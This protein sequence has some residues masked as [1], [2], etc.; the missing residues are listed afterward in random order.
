[1]V[2]INPAQNRHLHSVHGAA[3]RVR[4][5]GPF[6]AEAAGESVSI[7]SRKAK[8]VIAYLA[9][10]HGTE[11]ARGVLAGLLWGER[12][13]DQARAS[14]RQT[15]SEIRAAFS[16]AAT[17]PVAAK[18]EAVAW[19]TGAAWVDAHEIAAAVSSEDALTLNEAALLLRG[20]F[21]EGL[22]IGEPGFDQWLTVER[23]RVR[24]MACDI[25]A[26]LMESA[27]RDGTQENALLYG[28]RLL[29][30]D[31]LQE[32]VHR[33]L[34]RIYAAQNRPDAAL[35]QFER[36]KA[37]LAGQ[38]N[39]A[40]A[41]ETTNLER[42][43]KSARR[44]PLAVSVPKS[45][46]PESDAPLIL[47]DKPS[48]VVLP[49]INLSNDPAQDFIADGMTED[50]IS[51]LSRIGKLF[52]IARSSSFTFKGQPVRAPDAAKELGVQYVLEDSVRLAGER[53][54]VNAQLID[55]TSGSNIWTDRYEG[56]R[57][58]IFAVQDEITYQIVQAL[59]IKLARGDTAWLWESQTKNLRAW[60][61]MVVAR[62]VFQRYTIADTATARRLLEEA[63]EIDP[64]YSGA[65]AALGIT[66]YW[67]AR[68]TM[69]LDQTKSIE[70][71]GRQ[72][73]LLFSADS[74]M[75]A[76]FVLKG[77]LAYV[78]DRHEEAIS[79]GQRGVD[80]AP[81][82]PRA[83]GFLGMIFMFAGEP[84]K[85]FPH[86]KSAMMVTPKSDSWIRYY[87]TL[88]NLWSGQDA[89][90]LQS[91]EFYVQQE[92]DE[93]CGFMYLAAI[94]QMQSRHVDSAAAIARL[95]EIS[96][97]FGLANV[98][99]SEHYKEPEKLK[100]LLNALSRA[101]LEG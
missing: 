16:A 52:V 39:I 32:H 61:K 86:L 11:T 83:L 45:M 26:L 65:R 34:M 1:M 91:A 100:K 10:R 97:A 63:L 75:S 25:L 89:A 27:V 85:A 9:Q 23:E 44:I 58:D 90:A 51:A 80:L 62:E 41:P 101:G 67:D 43:I 5:I 88:A 55:R 98:R 6:S 81:G 31:P 94:H 68:F 99:R 69:S 15:L 12:S 13:D 76:A 93:P 28:Q 95:R 74:K 87:L 72:V 18:G 24:Q 56:K 46:S 71:A 20:E 29:S 49:F 60:E 59:E 84:E 42:T 14:L 21:L 48:I 50:I 54:R 38:L 40:P 4:L 8:A 53:V 47:T 36:C 78:L 92:P 19:V 82:D 37:I 66:H 22:E 70:L 35:A 57:D 64:H 7:S 17:Q 73:E 30:Y 79:H 33:T 3:I 77:A 96:H 2:S